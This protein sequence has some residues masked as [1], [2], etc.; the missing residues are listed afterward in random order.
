[1]DGCEDSAPSEV[2]VKPKRGS[3]KPSPSSIAAAHL[4]LLAALSAAA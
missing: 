3:P 4:L 2:L 1:M